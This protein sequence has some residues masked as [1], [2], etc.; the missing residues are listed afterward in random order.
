[1][2]TLLLFLLL[3]QNTQAPLST[4]AKSPQTI[5]TKQPET[6]A[7]TVDPNKGCIPFNDAVK[8]VGETVCVTG[9]VLQVGESKKS[10]TQFLN[11]CEDY[12]GCPFTVVVFPK[13]RDKV[14]DVKKLEG[15]TI[16]IH[17]K[18]QE[19]Q[20]QAE[21]I[22]ADADQLKG[23]VVKAPG[24]PEKYDADANGKYSPGNPS[25]N[26]KKTKKTRAPKDKTDP[27]M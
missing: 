6:K 23:P 21:I 27:G 11:F 1:M 9:K 4:E 12:R 8:K 7:Q 14:G 18:V 22:L 26:N 20:G 19:Y 5:V 10:G 25:K 15:Q 13:D 24:A 16:Y 17:G 2:L 3:S